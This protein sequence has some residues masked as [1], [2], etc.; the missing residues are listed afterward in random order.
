MT[1]DVNVRQRDQ[2]MP[3]I[4]P[5][6]TWTLSRQTK[7][8]LD[9]LNQQLFK[10]IFRLLRWLNLTGLSRIARSLGSCSASFRR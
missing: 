8:T 3:R 5:R 2:Q 4:Y 7:L 9:E 1:D 10:T 6:A